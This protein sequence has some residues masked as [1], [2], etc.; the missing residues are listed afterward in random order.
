MAKKKDLLAN[1]HPF[2]KYHHEGW[3]KYGGASTWVCI[4]DLAYKF[5]QWSKEKTCKKK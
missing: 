3:V 1:H 4:C 5:E 2:C